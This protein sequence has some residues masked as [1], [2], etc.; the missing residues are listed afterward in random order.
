MKQSNIHLSRRALTLAIT[1]AACDG[2]PEAEM[3][4]IDFN[5]F[6]VVSV[7]EDG[8]GFALLANDGR[9]IGRVEHQRL[10]GRTVL[11]VELA[12]LA[13]KFEWDD[14]G[15]QVGLACDDGGAEMTETCADS[16]DLGT[17]VLASAG[18]EIPGLEVE[19][20]DEFRSAC[21][22]VSTVAINCNVCLSRATTYASYDVWDGGSCTQGW[23]YA[24]CSHTF[25]SRGSEFELLLN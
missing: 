11:D 23:L 5:R 2:P 24:S 12:G 7:E 8:D 18:V 19:Q 16:L 22:V 20:S 6:G 1:L 25:C 15:Q 4:D 17:S 3:L 21:E 9:T 10:D 14:D 13:S